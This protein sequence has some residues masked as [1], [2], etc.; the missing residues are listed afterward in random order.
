MRELFHCRFQPFHRIVT[1]FEF[2]LIAVGQNDQWQNQALATLAPRPEG[3]GLHHRFV[4]DIALAL[5]GISGKLGNA[6]HITDAVITDPVS[7]AEILMRVVI[8]Q[9]PGNTTGDIRIGIA[10]IQPQMTNHMFMLTFFRIKAFGREH[11]SVI[12]RHQ[13]RY[14]MIQPGDLLLIP[15]RDGTA[16]QHKVIHGVD[17]FQE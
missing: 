14:F 1:E 12:F 13:I 17:I 4:A 16:I 10:G 5:I 11:M 2:D 9:T 7:T 3:H 6:K 15:E 8:K